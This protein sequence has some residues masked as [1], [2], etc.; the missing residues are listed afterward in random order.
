MLTGCAT[1][2]ARSVRRCSRPLIKLVSILS[3]ACI[4]AVL[5]MT[6]VALFALMLSFVIVSSQSRREPILVG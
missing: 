2:I 6:A 1:R 5:M 4:P 3:V